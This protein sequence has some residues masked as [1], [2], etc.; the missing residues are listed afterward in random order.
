MMTPHVIALDLRT[1]I[2]HTRA[3]AP[4]AIHRSHVLVAAPE[5]DGIICIAGRFI[6]LHDPAKDTWRDTKCRMRDDLAR[7]TAN[8][9]APY[10]YIAGTLALRT[11]P[12]ATHIITDDEMIIRT[13]H[14]WY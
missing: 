11:H 4:A 8:Y 10:L 1:N 7:F 12:I 6:Y 3:D 5:L 14:R 13:V 2:W 9:V